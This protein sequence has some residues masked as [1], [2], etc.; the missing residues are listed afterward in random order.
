[1]GAFGSVGNRQVTTGQDAGVGI[2]VGT[3]M[4]RGPLVTSDQLAAL[5]RI[6]WPVAVYGISRVLLLAMAALAGAIDHRSLD[7]ELTLFDGQWYLRLATSGYPAHASHA[8]STLG[9]F[10]LYPLVIRS[11][12]WLCRCS[13]VSAALV[14]S[15]L[16]GLV[17]T[18]LAE[19]LATSW[20]GE[21]TA[22][23]AVLV[24]CAFPGS[25]VFSMSYSECLTIPLALGCLLALGSKRWV[26]AG[27]LAGIATA[28]E[29]VALV[30]VLAC[31][32]AAARELHISGWHA[33]SAQRSL[34][35]PLLAPLGI[36]AFAI[37]LW[38]WTGTPFATYLA[39]RYGWY[40]QSSPLT[41]LS[42][43]VVR[44]LVHAPEAL[45]VHLLSWNLWN[46]VLGGI[47]LACSIVALLRV[48]HE[49]TSGALVLAVGVAAVT[50]WSVMTPPN[51]RM[52]LVASPAV[53]V[54]AR[55]LSR[56]SFALFV[57]VES[58]LLVLASFLTFT[59]RMLP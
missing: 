57:A 37:F 29:P 11:L 26:L 9:F 7:F 38:V 2:D 15:L 27:I 25:V 55:R 34:L 46:G 32:G 47:F 43:P 10:P 6:L 59:G 20:W 54:W 33:R 50:F 42:A 22:R 44:H 45:L 49:L 8:K 17:A 31:L 14:T 52:L 41:A 13:L 48:H 35:A 12:A 36:G 4:G 23:R 53:L 3:R 40:E 56:K 18:I 21:H 1:M 58:L 16:G 28:V 24:F 19:R 5:R 30:L 51:A 39:Q